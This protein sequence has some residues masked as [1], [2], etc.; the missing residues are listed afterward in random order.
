MNAPTDRGQYL[1]REEVGGEA[2]LAPISNGARWPVRPGAVYDILAKTTF[3][4]IS[5][6][7][8]TKNGRDLVIYLATGDQVVFTDYFDINDPSD[9]KAQ[10]EFDQSL[11]L[12]LSSLD[13]DIPTDPILPQAEYSP[14]AS[15]V[16]VTLPQQGDYRHPEYPSLPPYPYQD[17]EGWNGGGVLGL[18]GIALGGLAL[19]AVSLRS[20]EGVSQI[21]NSADR[22]ENAEGSPALDL[23]VQSLVERSASLTLPD[24]QALYDSI[25]LDIKEL[26]APKIGSPSETGSGSSLDLAVQSLL[27]RSASLTLP[28]DQALYDSIWL[29]IKDLL[30]TSESPSDA[31]SGIVINN[32]NYGT[33]S[34]GSNTYQDTVSSS[35]QAVTIVRSDNYFTEGE[36]IPVGVKFSDTVTAGDPENLTFE[37]NDG[38]YSAQYSSGNGSDTLTFELVLST[39]EQL[40]ELTA[41]NSALI[42]GGSSLIDS[43]NRNVDVTTLPAWQ[44]EVYVE[45]VPEIVE[46]TAIPD[47]GEFTNDLMV[48]EEIA[49][50]VKYDMPVEYADDKLTL[51]LNSGSSAEFVS[52]TGPDGEENTAYLKF[53][54]T[55][56][57]GGEAND[58]S[59]ELLPSALAENG[60][61]NVKTPNGSDA[62]TQISEAV[63]AQFKTDHDIIYDLSQPAIVSF[64]LDIQVDPNRSAVERDFG[65]TKGTKTLLPVS[66]VVTIIYDEEVVTEPAMDALPELAIV[67]L[68]TDEFNSQGNFEPQTGRAAYSEA[69]TRPDVNTPTLNSEQIYEFSNLYIELEDP[70][71]TSEADPNPNEVLLSAAEGLILNMANVVGQGGVPASS[72]LPDNP[73]NAVIGKV[74]PT[75]NNG[76]WA[77]DAGAGPFLA[78]SIA[79]EIDQY[80]FE[81]VEPL[82]DTL[83]NTQRFYM[84]YAHDS[85]DGEDNYRDEFTGNL[86]DLSIGGNGVLRALVSENSEIQHAFVTPISELMVQVVETLDTPAPQDIHNVKTAISSFFQ[87]GDFIYTEASF[88]NE[89]DLDGELIAPVDLSVAVAL[90]SLSA[91]DSVSGSLWHTLEILKPVFL[92]D[93]SREELAAAYKLVEGTRQILTTSASLEFEAYANDVD[94]L[95]DGMT[96]HL[97]QLVTRADD[98]LTLVHEATEY[99]LDDIELTSL[100][101]HESAKIF[102]GSEDQQAVD[103]GGGVEIFNLGD[104]QYGE[105]DIG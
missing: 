58:S 66:G 2:T 75:R 82:A 27:E 70:D 100:V 51:A 65:G 53:V 77:I 69:L 67:G 47:L 64:D 92:A 7:H 33:S 74:L 29:D 63:V 46:I 79:F 3:E 14:Q 103:F 19:A 81:T 61:A 99:A 13:Y 102:L 9:D 54:Y 40:T 30:Q 23:A 35:V 38:D 85:N 98:S 105:W 49:F 20:S 10:A 37:F 101:E 90:A 72:N 39:I 52:Q 12:R 24:D 91:M 62:R 1:I 36:I 104:V 80:F 28:D 76:G 45:P 25:Q 96:D 87:M 18:A 84:V 93:A 50:Y 83:Q 17:D 6:T 21:V 5:I 16:P 44:G 59:K 78:D 95:L 56:Q 31:D 97:V 43:N 26:L 11:P 15:N 57:D 48:G 89:I 8:A 34:G 73:A 94:S 88:I 22:N 86:T 32:N 42:L 4:N 71:A 55:L 41:S 68:L 60:G